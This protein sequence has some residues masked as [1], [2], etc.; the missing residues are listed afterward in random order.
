LEKSGKDEGT[1]SNRP[2]SEDYH[3]QFAQYI[4]LVPD[5]NIHDILSHQLEST[6]A[7]FAPI[8]EHRGNFRYASGKWSLKEVLGHI[9][10]NERIMS[11]RLLRIARGDR[12]PLT[13][14]NQD[15]LMKGIAFDTYTLPQLIEDYTLVRRSTLSLIRGLSEEAW[16][17]RGIV[18]D[19]EST[20]KAWAYTI[21]GHELHH[22][23]V[24]KDKYIE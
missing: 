4:T 10:D 5:G 2:L 8:P 19:N 17:R 21:A 23:N 9:T 13:G 3:P 6:T 16:S 22:L 12:T 7:F 20:S 18:N 14:Y 15:D 1:L 24:I 11:Y